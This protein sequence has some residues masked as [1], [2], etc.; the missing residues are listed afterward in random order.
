MGENKKSFLNTTHLKIPFKLLLEEHATINVKYTSNWHVC[1]SKL[2]SA[3]NPPCALP[4]AHI[5][6]AR[7]NH[8]A[9]FIPFTLWPQI[10]INS[11]HRNIATKEYSNRSER[12]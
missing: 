2:P 10:M 6:E 11:Q 5:A 4:T 8:R 9:H 7:V 12:Q 1:I 3:T